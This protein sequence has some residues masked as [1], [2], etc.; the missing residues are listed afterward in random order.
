MLSFLLLLL[1]KYSLLLFESLLLPRVDL[2]PYLVLSVHEHHW[3]AHVCEVTTD[4]VLKKFLIRQAFEIY[5]IDFTV[6]I[7]LLI[8]FL[9]P[10]LIRRYQIDDSVPQTPEYRADGTTGCTDYL[11]QEFAR[12]KGKFTRSSYP[13]NC[14]QSVGKAI[15]IVTHIAE[16]AHACHNFQELLVGIALLDVVL[17]QLCQEYL[18]CILLSRNLIGLKFQAD[19]LQIAQQHNKELQ[20]RIHCEFSEEDWRIGE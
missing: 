3:T 2:D 20:S 19:I 16:E 7:S 13:E 8:L 12:A 9:V 10:V 6:F 18:K 5:S 14:P 15:H 1:F 4:I 17:F 11:L